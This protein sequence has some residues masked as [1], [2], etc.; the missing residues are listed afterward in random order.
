[1]AHESGQARGTA[2]SPPDLLFHGT[3]ARN[4]PS[5]RAQGLLKGSRHHVHLSPDSTTA[6]QVGARHG[7][8]VVLKVRA[9]EMSVAG[10]EFYLSA[11]GVWLTEY[12]PAA[13]IDFGSG[14]A[15]VAG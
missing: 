13:F 10:H 8:P 5:I 4:L 12:V 7:S 3:A 11:N 1:M 2:S 15:S 9:G 14:G 6:T